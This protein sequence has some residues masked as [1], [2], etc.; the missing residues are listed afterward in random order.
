M[1]VRKPEWYVLFLMCGAFALVA[2]PSTQPRSVAI[3]AGR[4]LDVR[5]GTY[6]VQ[7]I[8]W[9]E[10]DRIKQIGAEDG[11]SGQLPAG[12][13]VI[14]LSRE[15]LLP[16]LIDCHTHLT[17]SPQFAAATAGQSAATGSTD[18]GGRQP[19]E[20]AKQNARITLDAGFTTVRDLG[21]PTY[22]D[23]ALRDAI[24]A[25]ETRGPRMLAAGRPHTG[26]ASGSVAAVRAAVLENLQRRTDV[27]KFFAT[28]GVVLGT[29]ITAETYSLEEMR[30]MTETAHSTGHKGAA[31]AH[32][33]MGIK[34]AV[35][36]GVD[37]IEHGS[38]IGPE[39]ISLMK[40]RG[41]Y[42]V[43]TVYVGQW[44]QENYSRLG[45][46]PNTAR[47]A[48]PG[49]LENLARAFREGVKVAFGSDSGTFPPGLNVRE[50]SAMVALGMTR[51]QAIQAAT[52]NAAELLGWS[53]RVG[54]LEVG[55]FADM[56][57]VDGDPLTDLKALE[58]VQHVVK[59]GELVK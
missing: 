40:Q 22:D 48:I 51:L 10:G 49:R 45:G 8:V 16:G 55:K 15:T 5:T 56:I 42:L 32:G 57:A 1:K 4:I 28:G 23:V 24:T 59:G 26:R 53:D 58:H 47:N 46:S 38:E 44:F 17:V 11:V 18:S 35:L 33:A 43:P 19:G 27:V 20:L 2:N 37:S 39:I 21:S 12:T 54:T 6:Q 7:Q 9:I 3:R 50:F 36:A 34:D 30:A 52:V 13:R 41:T 31:H 14:D 29:D 25:G